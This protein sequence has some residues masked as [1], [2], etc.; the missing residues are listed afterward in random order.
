MVRHVVHFMVLIIDRYLYG[1]NQVANPKF[2]KFHI[3]VKKI[4]RK[5]SILTTVH[6]KISQSANLLC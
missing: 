6:F 1:E 2:K 4:H 5:F 3:F